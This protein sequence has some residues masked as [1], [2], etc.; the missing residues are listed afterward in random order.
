MP[1]SSAETL[2]SVV[3]PQAPSFHSTKILDMRVDMLTRRDFREL[4]IHYI[5]TKKRGWFSYINIHTINVAQKLDW[6]KE[7][8][9]QALLSYCD[10]EG[11][12]FGA[13]LLGK[14]IPERITL[15]DFIYDIAEI[16]VEYDLKL[17]FLGGASSVAERAAKKLKELHPSLQISG[18]HHG[19]F[20]ELENNS[21][22]RTINACQ[23]DI[24]LLGMGV[25]LQEAWTKENFPKLN[26]NLIW[27]GGG[28][29]DT[30]SGDKINCP[31]WLG[32]IG[33]EWAFRLIQE[34]RRL[35]KRYL[36]GNPLFLLRILKS[37][38]YTS[39]I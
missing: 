12:R 20:S 7:F 22:V 29:L 39:A 31:R 8:N 26:V 4:S 3:E 37:R 36:I 13:R 15:S 18:Y 33:F 28:F 27:M 25:P 6:L 35:W 9:N 32:D 16:A 10:G 11:V 21:V 30:V 1:Y 19:F 5:R 24:L 34:P 14:Y 17:F 23:P 38:F 2:R